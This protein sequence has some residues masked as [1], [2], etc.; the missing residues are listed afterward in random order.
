M[1]E[2]IRTQN[3]PKHGER[4][5]MAGCLLKVELKIRARIRSLRVDE[6]Q[7]SPVCAK[8]PCRVEADSSSSRITPQVVER[9][10][11]RRGDQRDAAAR[12]DQQGVAGVRSVA[13]GRKN[14]ESKELDKRGG[15]RLPDRSDARRRPEL[16]GLDVPPASERSP[17]SRE[18]GIAEP[19]RELLPQNSLCEVM[20]YKGAAQPREHRMRTMTSSGS[21]AS[22]NARVGFEEICASLAFPPD[23]VATFVSRPLVLQRSAVEEPCLHQRRPVAA[24]QSAIRRSRSATAAIDSAASSPIAC[25][26]CSICIC[27]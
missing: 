6:A 8:H 10:V 25:A 9:D 21:R 5:R 11:P 2:R 4:Q 26:R 23:G 1:P 18:R 20:R 14:T 7:V 27:A 17:G 15:S 19:A 22:T 13:H 3:A 16:G 12:A 24:A